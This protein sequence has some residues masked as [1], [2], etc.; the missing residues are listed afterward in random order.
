MAKRGEAEFKFKGN[1]KDYQK[2]IKGIIHSTEKMAGRIKSVMKIASGALLGLGAAAGKALTAFREQDKVERQLTASI[3]ANRAGNQKL[4]KSIIATANALQKTTTQG[5]ETTIALA[6]M[7]LPFNNIADETIPRAIVAITDFAAATGKDAKAAVQSIAVALDDPTS[8]LSTLERQVGKFNEVTREQI[9]LLAKSGD[10]QGAQALILDVLEK[11][12]KGQAAAIAE[13]SGI[14]IQVSNE[15][16]DV[17]EKVGKKVNDILSPILE[18]FRD[19]LRE[20]NSTEGAIEKLADRLVIFGKAL[21]SVIAVSGVMLGVLKAKIIVLK[22][23]ALSW[24][25]MWA[26]A[27]GGLTILLPLLAGFFTYFYNSSES[28]KDT[29]HGIGAVVKEVFGGIVET[30]NATKNA[31]S[32]FLDKIAPNRN[33][34]SDSAPLESS[35]TID[36]GTEQT[37]EFSASG[38]GTIEPP[39][40][41]E[42]L[43]AVKENAET[44]VDINATKIQTIEEQNEAHRL[45]MLGIANELK[46]QLAL[47]KEEQDEKKIEALETQIAADELDKERK[48][49]IYQ[50]SIE[51]RKRLLVAEEKFGKKGVAVQK[52]FDNEKVQ[53]GIGAINALGQAMAYSGGKTFNFLKNFALADILINTGRAV[54]KAF[55]EI[56]FPYSLATAGLL[57]AKGIREYQTVKAQ[58]PAKFFDGSFSV[59]SVMGGTGKDAIPAMVSQGEYIASSAGGEAD[60]A[61]NNAVARQIAARDAGFGDDD[62]N[63][64]S[65]GGNVVVNITTTLDGEQIAFN[66]QEVRARL[67]I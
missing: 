39:D 58:Q 1:D 67:G 20:L 42:Y 5:D 36:S 4:Q 8:K 26:A 15:I 44:E 14:I 66:Q 60:A 17:W 48:E 29:V 37:A 54:T 33:K 53:S 64:G 56:P 13:N 6:N 12:Y 57:T 18:P 59:P 61:R 30:F 40:A 43:S 41:S 23:A 35:A 21:L 49:R 46:A 7:L 3:E 55:A 63:A 52:F 31:I 25:G 47:D 65:S 19:W 32:G 9:I 51:R 34:A 10:K 24:R 38:G 27:T 22:L 2:K 16:G 11:K 50:E 28:F 45:K 62:N